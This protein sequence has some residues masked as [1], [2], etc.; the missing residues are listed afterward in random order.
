M[1]IIKQVGI[2]EAQQ[3]QKDFYLKISRIQSVFN[4]P[5]NQYNSF[6]KYKFRN[7]EDILTALKPVLE[8]EGLVVKI[9]DDVE[10]IGDRYYIRS[11]VKLTDGIYSHEASAYAR[12]CLTK[13]GMDESQITGAASSYARKYA[14]GGLLCI[15]DNKDADSQPKTSGQSEQSAPQ[16]NYRQQALVAEIKKFMSKQPDGF[17]MSEA[18]KKKAWDSIGQK[19]EKLIK[20][21]AN[22]NFDEFCNVAT[23]Q[24]NV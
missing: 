14:L 7:C 22:G 4:A 17:T 11:I 8:S 9:Q 12:E 10:L 2:S 13:K 5:K 18:V 20:L 1:T 21:I 19:R 3:E 6:G 16:V 15:D 24:E 23:K